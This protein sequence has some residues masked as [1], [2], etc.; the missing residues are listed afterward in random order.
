MVNLINLFLA[1]S[2]VHT[3]ADLKTVTVRK[4]PASLLGSHA[5][6]LTFGYLLTGRRPHLTQVWSASFFMDNKMSYDLR[7]LHLPPLIERILG[8]HRCQLTELGR[9]TALFYS[10]TF[11]HVL[12]PGLSQIHNL[13]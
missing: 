8:T 5:I 3:M 6:Y 9:R 11:N 4:H 13:E 2:A 7:R 1:Q 10:R 12:R